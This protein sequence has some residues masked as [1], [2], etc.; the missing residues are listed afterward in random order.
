MNIRWDP[1]L[2]SEARCQVMRGLAKQHPKVRHFVETGTADG[3][4]CEYLRQDFDHLYTIEIVPSLHEFSKKR[5]Q[6]YS[7]IELLLGDSTSILPPLLARINAPCFFWLDGHF[8]G[9]REAR[10]LKDT[11]VEDELQ[12]I[13][14][15]KI[16]HIIIIDDA[17]L[18][19]RDPAYPTIERI[20][21]LVTGQD[22]EYDFSYV[23]DMMRAI[24]K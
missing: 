16:P 3:A 15:T 19:G 13:L 17:R 8:C 20:R 18:F 4:T 5:L 6:D 12:I 23:D 10:G 24:P 22:I 2:T 7:N 9:S 14:A 11:P 1:T 21:E